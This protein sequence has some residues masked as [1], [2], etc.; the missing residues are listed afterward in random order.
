MPRKRVTLHCW[1]NT[2]TA[3]P[4]AG[5]ATTLTTDGIRIYMDNSYTKYISYLF[6]VARSEMYVVRRKFTSGRLLHV[7]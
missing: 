5:P 1:T 2:L 6:D 7:I 4:L 3:R